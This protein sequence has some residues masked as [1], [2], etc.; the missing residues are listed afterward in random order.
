MIVTRLYSPDD[1]VIINERV[2]TGGEKRLEGKPPE[3]LGRKGRPTVTSSATN[4]KLTSSGPLRWET[5]YYPPE[6]WHGQLR[7]VF[8]GSSLSIQNGELAILRYFEAFLSQES[9]GIESRLDNK[10]FLNKSSK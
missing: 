8:R 9:T 10:C 6:L 4:P 3:I 7:I 5:S 1:T 2:A